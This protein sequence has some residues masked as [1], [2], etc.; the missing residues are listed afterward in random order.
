MP[1]RRAIF[2]V[3]AIAAGVVTAA[4]SRPRISQRSVPSAPALLSTSTAG[5]STGKATLRWTRPTNKRDTAPTRYEYALSTNGGATWTTLS[6]RTTGTSEIVGCPNFP[7]SPCKY[8]LHAVNDYGASPA[9]DIVTIAAAR[10]SAPTGLDA[11]TRANLPRSD[12]TQTVS[13]SPPQDDGGSDI[14][15]YEL[16]MCA[17]SAV[18]SCDS[19]ATEWLSAVPIATVSAAITRA[20]LVCA[21]NH[22]CAY[23]IRAVNASGAGAWATIKAGSAAVG[24]CDGVSVPSGESIQSYIDAHPAG[25][26]FC[27]AGSYMLA[28]PLVPLTGDAFI[29][30]AT[31][32]GN[33][34][35]ANAFSGNANKIDD[36]T[37]RRLTVQHFKPAPQRVALDLS[38]GARWIIENNDVAYNATEGIEVSTHGIVRG[39]HV[40]H[41]GQ[42]GLAGYRPVGAMIID[43]EVD[44]NNTAFF[45]QS[46]E[47][48]G[49]KIVG[50][51]DVT[52]RGNNVHDNYGTGIWLDTND[53]HYVLAENTVVNNSHH[54]I[55]IEAAFAGTL[56]DNFVSMSGFLD[57][58]EGSTNSGINIDRS[59]PT[60]EIGNNVNCSQ[61]L[62]YASVNASTVL[63]AGDNSSSPCA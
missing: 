3:L 54:G 5:P 18:A 28:A 17:G 46:R 51:L 37:I 34:Q 47:A 36:V 52:I 11:T 60:I 12:T 27:L 38:P 44:H 55:K 56:Y 42:L 33:T 22:R 41:N 57:P 53:F 4:C 49:I 25:T 40:H 29:G 20:T 43:N 14:I 21:A 63:D 50:S 24:P 48:G 58:V 32:D 35:T 62:N 45:D 16:E 7:T 59:G 1:A 15:R 26:V 61:H 10:P 30:P 31:L 2:V 39:N 19:T 9:S 8:R 23:R 13:W 6:F